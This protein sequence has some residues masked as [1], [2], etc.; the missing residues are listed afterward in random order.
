MSC[1]REEVFREI[2]VMARR[3]QEKSKVDIREQMI[4]DLYRDA[5]EIAGAVVTVEVDKKHYIE[6]RIDDMVLSRRFGYPL[7]ILLL[8]T[9]FWL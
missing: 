4:G 2:D 6:K 8:G 9:V 3:I 5:E 7:M 1:E